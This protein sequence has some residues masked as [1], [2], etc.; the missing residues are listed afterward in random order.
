M[1]PES[2]ILIYWWLGLGVFSFVIGII[3]DIIFPPEGLV[4]TKRDWIV[5]SILGVLFGPVTL[6]I[7]IR[8]IWERRK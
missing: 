3:S 4:M 1:I 7:V 6:L 8:S 5:C 2:M